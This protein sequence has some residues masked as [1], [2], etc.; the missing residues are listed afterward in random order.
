[1]RFSLVAAALFSILL[2]F[3]AAAIDLCGGTKAVCT[4]VAAA[5]TPAAAVSSRRDKCGC[6]GSGLAFYQCHCQCI[7]EPGFPCRVSHLPHGK[8]ACSCQ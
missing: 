7:S 4:Q 5:A 6:F 3:P 1:M 2:T 8:F